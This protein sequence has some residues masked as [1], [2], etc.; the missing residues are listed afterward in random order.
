MRT[1]RPESGNGREEYAESE[2]TRSCGRP[3]SKLV[4]GCCTTIMNRSGITHLSPTC[5]INGEA[6]AVT[7]TGRFAQLQV[8]KWVESHD[9]KVEEGTILHFF[10]PSIDFRGRDRERRG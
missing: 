3:R 8:D 1:E 2:E 10:V 9:E 6:S 4:E 5:L 7:V